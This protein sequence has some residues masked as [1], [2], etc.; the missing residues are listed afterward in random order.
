MQKHTPV[1]VSLFDAINNMAVVLALVVF[2]AFL[3][4]VSYKALTRRGKTVPAISERHKDKITVPASVLARKIRE[5]EIKAEEVMIAYIERIKE[6][7]S[8]INAIVKD[9]FELALDEARQVDRA[10]ANMTEKEKE[11]L[12][13]S[14]VLFGVPFTNKECFAAKGM[15]QS[16]G[17]VSRKDFIS[18]ENADVVQ[19]LQDAGAILV[20]VSNVSELCMWWES[21]NHLY[22]RTSNPYDSERIV[23]GSSGGEAAIIAA[24]GSLIGTGSGK[25]NWSTVIPRGGGGTPALWLYS[26]TVE[27]DINDYQIYFILDIGGSIRMPAFFNGVFGHKP[28]PGVVSN[29]GQFPNAV[30]RGQRLLATGPICRYATDLRTV[31]KVLIH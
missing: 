21:S 8:F 10:L 2:T 4:F 23:G 26:Y 18:S 11:D 28:S 9:R 5:G 29:T 7:N 19:R 30:P 6:V 24:A 25:N 22:G 17:L 20:A 1:P 3:V 15:P 27:I 12:I 13:Q 14:K 31:L 16:S